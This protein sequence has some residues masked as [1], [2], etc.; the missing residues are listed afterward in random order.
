[1]TTTT[2]RIPK[3]TRVRWRA[4]YP[5][6]PLHEGEVLAF[7][8]RRARSAP[9]VGQEASPEIRRSCGNRR[10]QRT[11]SPDAPGN[12]GSAQQA[13]Q[14]DFLPWPPELDPLPGSIQQS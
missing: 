8:D 13:L 6:D 4:R 2:K 7:V 14:A 1:M 3:G 5:S 11:G 10:V 9:G 12:L